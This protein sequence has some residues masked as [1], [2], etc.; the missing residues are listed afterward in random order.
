M[1]DPRLNFP[2]TRLSSRNIYIYPEKK[3]SHLEKR[4]FVRHRHITVQFLPP[5]SRNEGSRSGGRRGGMKEK[6]AERGDQYRK[7]RKYPS[8]YLLTRIPHKT[9]WLFFLL[10]FF[11]FQNICFQFQELSKLDSIFECPECVSRVVTLRKE[12][13]KRERT[14]ERKRRG[15][16]KNRGRWKEARE[17]DEGNSEG[18]KESRTMARMKRK[19]EKGWGSE[20]KI[21]GGG[22]YHPAH[23]I[24]RVSFFSASPP[25]RQRSFRRGTRSQVFSGPIRDEVSNGKFER[26][27]TTFLGNKA[28]RAYS[29]SYVFTIYDD[30]CHIDVLITI[31]LFFFSFLSERILLQKI[32]SSHSELIINNII[33]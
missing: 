2:S 26:I 18:R 5:S 21:D 11:F 7:H 22:M 30:I 19:K 9:L 1:I 20:R 17:K 4:R 12:K 8:G 13:R 31:K 25:A 29:L 15:G 10:F 28:K 3:R 24:F 23:S 16:R 14:K 27:K 32:N 6:Q 33:I